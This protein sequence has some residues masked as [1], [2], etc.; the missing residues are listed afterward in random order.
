MNITGDQL[1]WK[2]KRQQQQ[3]FSTR[4]FMLLSPSAIEHFHTAVLYDI[5]FVIAA[6][7]A[8]ITAVVAF[9][10][11]GAVVAVVDVVAVVANVAAVAAVAIVAASGSLRFKYVKASTFTAA[12]ISAPASA[13]G[14]KYISVPQTSVVGH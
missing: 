5:A 7:D 1:N 10:T 6:V 3:L 14:L 8:L 12:A 11:V 2:Q 9:I 13:V 4:I